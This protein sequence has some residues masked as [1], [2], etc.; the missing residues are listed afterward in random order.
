MDIGVSAI[1]MTCIIVINM[2]HCDVILHHNIKALTFLHVWVA[3]PIR[4]WVNP[5]YTN[6]IL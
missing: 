2:C 4:Q 3:R 1:V 6:T 5:T